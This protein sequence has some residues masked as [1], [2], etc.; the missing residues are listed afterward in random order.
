M[1]TGAGF[2]AVT[3]LAEEQEGDHDHRWGDN[4]DVRHGP[5]E[6]DFRVGPGEEASEQQGEDN[7]QPARTFTEQL[8]DLKCDRRQKHRAKSEVED[9]PG[10]PAQEVE[11]GFESGC[12]Q[13][14]Q[15]GQEQNKNDDL[16]GGVEV[17]ILAQQAQQ[18]LHYR[19]RPERSEVQPTDRNGRR[20]KRH[21]LSRRL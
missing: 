20:L 7:H 11:Q 9:P 1:S 6:A 21:V 2:E 14:G 4:Q 13:R 19:Q 3:G 8:Q 12:H 16:G 17:R 15:E 10:G 5:E 18:W